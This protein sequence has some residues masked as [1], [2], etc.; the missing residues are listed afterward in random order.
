MNS[1][2]KVRF[3]LIGAGV[4]GDVHA[5]ALTQLDT[6]DLVAIADLDESKASIVAAS[7]AP[8]MAFSSTWN[9]LRLGPQVSSPCS[10][11]PACCATVAI[12][13]SASA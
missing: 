7:S 11:R 3:A 5:R 13:G 8:L 10:A 4:I 12:R 9:S 6:A 2:A 1:T